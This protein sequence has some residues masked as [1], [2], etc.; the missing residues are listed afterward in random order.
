MPQGL[1]GQDVQALAVDAS[2]TVWAATR[3][4]LSRIK[5]GRVASIT[6]AQ[7]LPANYFYQIVEDRGHLWMT[8]ARGIAR[9]SRSIS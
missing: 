6:A 1:A 3:Q 7:G 5:D 8:Y 2:G 4:G 9:I